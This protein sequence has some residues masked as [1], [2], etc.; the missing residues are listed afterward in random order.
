MKKKSILLIALLLVA[1]LLVMACTTIIVTKGASADGS[2][3][4]THTAD[5]GSCDFRIL[6]VP[7]KDYEPG[8]QRAVYPFKL[9][10][11]RY[12]GESRG[13]GYDTAGH[14][15]MEPL[16]YI[17]Q[18]EHT[19]AYIDGVYGVINEHQ[20]AI[21]ECTTGAKVYAVEEPGVRIFDIA[22]LSRVAMERCTTAREAVELMG[23]LAVEFGYYGWGETLTV[24]DT[25]EAWVFEMTGDPDKKSALWAAKKVPDGTVFVEANEFRIRELDPNDPDTMYSPNL[26]QIA[27]D[28]EWWDPNSGELLDWLRTV[29]PGEYSHPYYSLRRVWGVL[30][31]VAPSL[32]LSPW[33]EDGYTKDYPFSVVPDEKVS[34]QDV[35]ELH[36]YWYQGT[37]F[38]LGEGL[39]A[40]PFGTPNR[41]AGGS[42]LV[43]GAW[44]RPVSIFRCDYSFV[45]QL[46]GDLPDPIGGVLWFGPDA[47]H[48]TA[49]VPFYS[50]I[51][52]IPPQYSTGSHQE[53]DPNVAFW[54]HS[55][56]GNWAD[57]KFNYVIEDIR[58]MQKKTED[59]LVLMQPAIEEAA[60]ALYHQDPELAIEFLTNYCNDTA[61]DVVEEWWNFD[62]SLIVKY[63][64]GYVDGESVGYPDRWLKDVGYEDGPTDYA[65]P[66]EEK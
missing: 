47:P 19:Y 62:M 33:V 57:L 6:K 52:E 9:P 26:H 35:F 7:A 64:D 51:T 42:K 10:Y 32:E 56:A 59:K 2:V 12:V 44:E 48:T 46:R 54:V 38:D 43:K 11:P 53:F 16:G 5:C 4:V 34:L 14:E 61:K 3:M 17:D 65:K 25:E 23:A 15:E 66:T 31:R 1:G 58:A 22:A 27:A 39:A 45:A 13:P 30:N 41:Y 37:E 63:N 55:F 40:G 20:L 60:V 49:Y 18:V 8:S 24:A 28:N 36:R 29:S 50:G 21:G